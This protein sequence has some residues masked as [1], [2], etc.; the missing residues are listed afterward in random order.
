M[1][2][3]VEVVHRAKERGSG[4]VACH[5]KD[6]SGYKTL[7]TKRVGLDNEGTTTGGSLTR[8]YQST[9][10]PSVHYRFS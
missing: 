9:E 8:P 10:I 5:D 2:H 1:R 3:D 6:K 4:R 7:G